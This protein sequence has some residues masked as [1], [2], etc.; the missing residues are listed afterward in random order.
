MSGLCAASKTKDK[1]IFRF[2]FYLNIGHQRLFLSVFPLL[3]S[4]RKIKKDKKV[5][6]CRI[7]FCHFGLSKIKRNL[8]GYRFILFAPFSPLL[9]PV[10]RAEWKAKVEETTVLRAPP[11][12]NPRYLPSR[13]SS[14]GK[15]LARLSLASINLPFAHF[16]FAPTFA[17]MKLFFWSATQK[18]K[19]KPEEMTMSQM[20]GHAEYLLT[21]ASSTG[22]NLARLIFCQH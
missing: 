14:H 22:R 10:M 13:A 11:A 1:V 20:A 18:W 6:T 3:P 19:A 5:Q 21:I 8:S 4:P 17:N 16:V 9:L 2:S 7:S 12:A 15:I